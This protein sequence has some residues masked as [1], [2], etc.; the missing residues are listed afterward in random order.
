MGID[1][2]KETHTAVMLDC[3]NTKLG[4]I[5]FGNRP[6]EFPKLIRKVSRFVTEE[7]TAV[8]G[9][10]NAYGYGR[11]L[12]VWL[13]EK[14]F[15]VKDV[16]TALS[17]AQRKSVPMYQKS[18]SYDAEAVALVLINMLDKLPDAIPDDKYWTLGQLVNRRDN[19]CTHLHRLKNQ[20]HEQLCM[21]YPSYK[22]F[23]SDISRAT[24]LYFFKEYPSPEHLFGKTAEELAAELRPISHNNCSI[25]RAEKILEPVRTDGQTVQ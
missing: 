19:I 12:A 13:I 16:N 4:E 8:Y 20:L 7:K 11:A 1:L 3:W 10:E 24:A 17:Y 14:G 2:H 18:D 6:S 5:T 22:Q 15:H 21:A 23:F 9:L 25:K